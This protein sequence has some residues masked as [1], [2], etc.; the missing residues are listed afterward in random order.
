MIFSSCVWM[1]LTLSHRV[2]GCNE[3]DPFF[4]PFLTAKDH[5][6][7]ENYPKCVLHWHEGPCKDG[8]GKD[9]C[10]VDGIG[11]YCKL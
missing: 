4:L 2:S 11:V 9:G 8:W 7:C 6:I 1:A 3:A 10:G 5:W